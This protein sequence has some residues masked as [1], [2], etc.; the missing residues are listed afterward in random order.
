MGA[1]MDPDEFRLAVPPP[2]GDRDRLRWR[3]WLALVALLV[4]GSLAW[5]VLMLFV[6]PPSEADQQARP[7]WSS[8]Y[9]PR[10]AEKSTSTEDVRSGAPGWPPS[11]AGP[12]IVW[13]NTRS[14]VYHFPGYRWYGTT[15][16]GK[17]TSERD[18]VAEGN[19]AALN[20]RRPANFGGRGLQ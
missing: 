7:H 17:Y 11:A 12:G 13:V 9:V 10:P 6:W 1:T 2:F 8:S 3:A 5:T 16:K 14:G 4:I 15:I 18:A 20:E 19:R